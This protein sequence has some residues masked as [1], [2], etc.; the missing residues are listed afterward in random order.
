MQVVIHMNFLSCS[1]FGRGRHALRRGVEAQQH[2]DLLLL[3]QAH[4]FVD[5]DVGLALGVG[6]DRLDLVALDPALLDEVVDHDL[7][8]GVL[9]LRAAARERAGQVVDDA[10]LDL[11]L[12]RLG[13]R[14]QPE[15]RNGGQ[16]SAHK[17]PNLALGHASL[18]DICVLFTFL[19]TRI[20]G[21]VPSDVKRLAAGLTGLQD[22]EH[23][24][25]RLIEH[26]EQQREPRRIAVDLERARR[27]R[28]LC[29]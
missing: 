3:D 19:L 6:V 28:I 5:R 23:Q 12:L 22:V 26:A 17:A 4:G 2:V 9:Q 20:T 7:G 10:D 8:A 14:R 18:P 21:A 13:G 15:R 16:C 25:R 29:A 1:T 24:A 27:Q 11:L